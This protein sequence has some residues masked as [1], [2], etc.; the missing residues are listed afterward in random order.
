[1]TYTIIYY[2]SNINGNFGA[3]ARCYDGYTS[4]A[5]AQKDIDSLQDCGNVAFA[6]KTSEVDAWFD[7][8]ST[9]I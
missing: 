6:I 2:P 9:I 4:A 3:W 8:N 1:M 5:A 7:E